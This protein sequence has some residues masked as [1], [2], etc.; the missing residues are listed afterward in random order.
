MEYIHAK[1]KSKGNRPVNHNT[2][3]QDYV[4]KWI[5]VKGIRLSSQANRAV[6]EEYK[7]ARSQLLKDTV[8][9]KDGTENKE[10]IARLRQVG[11][12]DKDIYEVIGK[13]KTPNGYNYHHMF[14]RAISGSFK[15]GPVQFGNDQLTSIHDWRCMLPLPN[16]AHNDIH[17]NVHAAM[18]Q[19]NGVLPERPGTKLTYYIA[20][21]LSA[22]E[23]QMYKENPKS[24]KAELLVVNAH[25]YQT[26]NQNQTKK[27]MSVADIAK[28]KA[29]KIR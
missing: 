1:R 20:V 9:N 6:Y 19:R 23:Y 12:N 27:T 4:F 8:Y 22:E 18:D 13:G 14:P 24:V 15:E 28:L 7:E 3:Q 16:S 11:L 10:G 29:S 21:P 25:S 5:P 26:I 17:K 2:R